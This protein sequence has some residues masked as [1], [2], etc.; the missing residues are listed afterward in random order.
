M[1]YA[2]IGQLRDGL[3]RYLDQVRDGSEIL[4]LDR[5]RPVARI[6]PAGSAYPAPGGEADRLL[7]LERRGLLRRGRRRY[8]AVLK[9]GQPVKVRGSVLADLRAERES[10]W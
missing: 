8:P 1:K 4:V 10:G 3:S 6:V 9:R 2:K 7:D 5:D